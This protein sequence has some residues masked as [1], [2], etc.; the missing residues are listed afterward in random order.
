[1]GYADHVIEKRRRDGKTFFVINDY[2]RLRGLF[3]QLL[4]RAA[5]HQVDG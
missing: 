5:A 1:M 3:G 4:A 2:V